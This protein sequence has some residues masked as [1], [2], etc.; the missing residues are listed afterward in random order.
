MGIFY[1]MK[2]LFTKNKNELSF[3]RQYTY[4]GLYSREERLILESLNTIIS[5]FIKMEKN[6]GGVLIESKFN[7]IYYPMLDLDSQENFD[8]FKQLY[9][10]TPYVIFKSS[11]DQS[12]VDLD[13]Y[14]GFLDIPYKKPSIIFKEHNWK[15][16]NDQK[17]ISF[18]RWC[19]KILIR[20]LYENKDR[21]PFIFETNEKMST[22]FQLFINKLCIYY[23]KEG[24]ELSVLRYHDPALLILFNRKCK[25]KQINE[26]NE[27]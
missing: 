10:N 9:I 20:G 11:I 23:N 15:I 24:L 7:G 16:C 2:L 14:W 8:L 13:H 27:K 19:N 18:S 4:N 1:R 3:L 12:S 21:K 26:T 17:Y 6:T 5:K 25:L 22:N